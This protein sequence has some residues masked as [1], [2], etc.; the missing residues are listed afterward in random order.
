MQNINFT[1]KKIKDKRYNYAKKIENKKC[2]QHQIQS[3]SI[4]M[5]KS[6][7]RYNVNHSIVKK[8]M[9]IFKLFY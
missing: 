7:L 4:V 9:S 1:K 2:P 6:F 8:S 3:P 5:P